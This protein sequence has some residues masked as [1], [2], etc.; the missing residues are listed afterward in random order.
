MITFLVI[1]F[2]E[3]YSLRV[4]SG[5]APSGIGMLSSHSDGLQILPLNHIMGVSPAFR[6][7]RLGVKSLHFFANF[8]FQCSLSLVQLLL[9]YF[10]PWLS[11][12]LAL[13][14][15]AFYCIL[16]IYVNSRPHEESHILNLCPEETDGPGAVANNT[17]GLLWRRGNSFLLC[18]TIHL[19]D[20]RWIKP[21]TI[22]HM[23][24]SGS[25]GKRCLAA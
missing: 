1:C 6:S 9:A 14:Y 25:S 7:H 22:L 5:D 3:S 4:S 8:I 16:Y 23:S 13:E 17:V 2:W 15:I 12:H 18:R 10:G 21:P 19:Q 24:W 20:L 11:S